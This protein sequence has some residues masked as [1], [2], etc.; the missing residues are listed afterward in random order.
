MK[1][2]AFGVTWDFKPL[3]WFVGILLGMF[4][5]SGMIWLAFFSLLGAESPLIGLCALVGAALG[6]F[7]PVWILGQIT[8]NR[9]CK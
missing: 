7:I 1:A 5:Y 6:A 4:Y 8:H 9:E 2:K 3:L